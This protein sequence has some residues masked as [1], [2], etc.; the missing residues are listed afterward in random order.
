MGL[1]IPAI[2]DGG[3]A[4]AHVRLESCAHPDLRAF[5]GPEEVY[6]FLWQSAG[7][8]SAATE[9]PVDEPDLNDLPRGLRRRRCD[10][11]D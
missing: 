8:L 3:C 2:R 11:A 10:Q 9:I 5:E 6:G 4:V 7:S 1:T